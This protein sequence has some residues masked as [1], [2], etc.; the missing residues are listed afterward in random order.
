MPV[1]DM[2]HEREQKPLTEE[3]RK[4]LEADLVAVRARQD[5]INANAQAPASR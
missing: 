4:R 1:H 5:R 3:Q 2:P